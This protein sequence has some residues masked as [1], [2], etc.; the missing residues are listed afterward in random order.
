MIRSAQAKLYCRGQRWRIHIAYYAGG[1]GDLRYAFNPGAGV[2]RITAMAMAR[3]RSAADAIYTDCGSI[4]DGYSN[5]R[6]LQ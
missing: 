6:R 5:R 3:L 2:A 4:P 1:W